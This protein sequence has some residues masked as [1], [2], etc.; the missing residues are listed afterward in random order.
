MFTDQEFDNS[1][2]RYN[3]PHRNYEE[4]FGERSDLR[5]SGKECLFCTSKSLI[6]RQLGVLKQVIQ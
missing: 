4:S 6:M 5:S 3:S 1:E 2:V